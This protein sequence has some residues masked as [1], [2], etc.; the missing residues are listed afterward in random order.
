MVRL[1]PE[2]VLDLRVRNL[3]TQQ[4]LAAHMEVSLFTVQRIERGE[5]GVRPATARS[6]AR[7]LK[8]SPGD[9]LLVQEREEVQ[10]GQGSFA[11]FRLL[12]VG[13]VVGPTG[14]AA[15]GALVPSLRQ[16]LGLDAIVVN[17]E[18]STPSG[19]GITSREGAE[20]LSTADFLTLGDHAFRTE[21][22][23]RW[24]DDEKRVVRP[25]NLGEGRSGRGWSTFDASG[26]RLG[27]ASVMGSVFM[28]EEAASPTET[29]DQVVCE[30]ENSGADLMLVDIHA[31]AT[32][33][34][35]A[36]G[37]HLAGRVTA[38]LGT[39]THCPTFDLKVLPGGTAYVT[40]VGMTGGKDGVIGFARD[41]FSDPPPRPA[42]A[43]A[44]L[45]GVLV[46]V[47]PESGH[48]VA[49]ARIFREWT[50]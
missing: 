28:N 48:A 39:H 30:L 7:V 33:E 25:A 32:A 38:V 40:D 21:G 35:Q 20:L 24:L 23:E 6:L 50:P 18:N 1:S 44:R 2:R 16:E 22:V 17:G 37:W 26:L 36:L 13:D 45:D 5:G 43:P 27:V 15:F 9:L 14:L 12:F 41:S 10:E 3:M 47:S 19:F 11:P 46:D 49:A 29:A 8:V 4:E 34:K 31:E 42:E